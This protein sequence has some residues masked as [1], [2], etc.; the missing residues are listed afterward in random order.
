MSIFEADEVAEL[1][2]RLEQKRKDA[3]IVVTEPKRLVPREIE[4]ITAEQD[5][6][7]Q[8]KR[9]ALEKRQT[10]ESRVHN[11]NV[12]IEQRGERYA[13]CTLENYAI[14]SQPQSQ[15]VQKICEYIAKIQDRINKGMNLILFGPKGTGKDHLL[16]VAV[17]EAIRNDFT[18]LW[19]NGMDLFGDVR[20]LFDR[21]MS[22]KEFLD[23]L[24]RPNVLYI[25]DPL[26]P[27]GKLT[28]FQMTM[29]FRLLDARYSRMRPVWC[30]VNVSGPAEAEERLASQNVDRLRDGALAI[31]CN[32]ESYRRSNSNG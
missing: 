22:E 15:A 25:S 32:W 10:E 2:Q 21:K 11:W 29:L 26:P 5:A 20:D 13:N 30:S 9:E 23:K 24:V 14:D 7:I 18:V 4:I 16:S 19:R 1:Q 12:F 31:H 3:G 27:V 28:E 6:L 8:A 17:R